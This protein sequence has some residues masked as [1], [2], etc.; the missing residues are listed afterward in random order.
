[1]VVVVVV[2]VIIVVIVVVVVVAVVVAVLRWKRRMAVMWISIV[3][4]A[5]GGR[6]R[7]SCPRMRQLVLHMTTGRR[8]GTS[9]RGTHLTETICQRLLIM[10]SAG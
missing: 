1:M 9:S 6:C 10:S 2:L 5:A 7:H 3:V 4:T 8:C